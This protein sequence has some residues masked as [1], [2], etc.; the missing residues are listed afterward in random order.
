M[1]RGIGCCG[2][3]LRGTRLGFA[4]AWPKTPGN[5]KKGRGRKDQRPPPCARRQVSAFW[6]RSFD[7]RSFNLWLYQHGARLNQRLRHVRRC[8]PA[9]PAAL[10]GFDEHGV[11]GGVSQCVAKSVDGAADA[12]VEVYEYTFR[13][14]RPAELL[15]A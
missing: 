15:P 8:D 14:E 3:A 4:M 11:V 7:T 10:Y 2:G 9:I 5:Q 13:P 1:T 6:D 12:V